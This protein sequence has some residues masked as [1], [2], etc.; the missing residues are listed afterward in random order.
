MINID[1]KVRRMRYTARDLADLR[2]QF[3]R[4]VGAAPP[5]PRHQQHENREAD[6]RVDIDP[7]QLCGLR[8]II[9][10]ETEYP[11]EQDEG[12]HD[13]VQRHGDRSVAVNRRWCGRHLGQ[14]SRAERH[15]SVIL[16]FVQG[17]RSSI[18]GC[19]RRQSA[20]HMNSFIRIRWIRPECKLNLGNVKQAGRD[21]LI[22]SQKIPATATKP[23]VKISVRT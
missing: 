16:R 5:N 1:E 2:R 14:I 22:S 18:G 17:C 11:G 21:Y 3:G 20:I 23:N 9:E 6:L 8:P 10:Q 19:G 13:P 7:E 12:G 4:P 15:R